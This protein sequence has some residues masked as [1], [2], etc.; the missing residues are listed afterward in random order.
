[1]N[2]DGI[3]SEGTLILCTVPS[4]KCKVNIDWSVLLGIT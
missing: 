3:E 1:M 4:E 2:V